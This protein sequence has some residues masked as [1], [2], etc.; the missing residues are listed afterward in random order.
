MYSLIDFGMLLSY[1]T[2]KEK[3]QNFV[4]DSLPS[5]A[6]LGHPGKK[7]SEA[8]E[9]LFSDLSLGQ[10]MD[11]RSRLGFILHICCCTNATITVN[12]ILKLMEITEPSKKQSISLTSIITFTFKY[13][14]ETKKSEL[15]EIYRNSIMKHACYNDSE[16]IQSLIRFLQ[17]GGRFYFPLPEDLMK[18]FLNY[19]EK[20]SFVA[21]KVISSI[22]ELNPT[23]YSKIFWEWYEKTQNDGNFDNIFSL[24]SLICASNDLLPPKNDFLDKIIKHCES[25]IASDISFVST[26]SALQVYKWLIKHKYCVPRFSINFKQMNLSAIAISCYAEYARYGDLS[27]LPELPE[28]QD[29]VLR[30]AYAEMIYKASFNPN[31]S[32]LKIDHPI[33]KAIKNEFFDKNSNDEEKVN[34][35]QLSI[36][37]IDVCIEL[38]HLLPPYFFVHAMRASTQNIDLMSR[39]ISLVCECPEPVLV[40]YLE[41]FYSFVERIINKYP[42]LAKHLAK[43]IRKLI[44][45][46]RKYIG[47]LLSRIHPINFFNIDELSAKFIVIE[48]LISLSR[49][50]EYFLDDL[51]CLWEV[52]PFCRLSQSFC[53]ALFK[54]FEAISNFSGKETEITNLA[55][56]TI[57]PIFGIAMPQNI[58]ILQ[59][60]FFKACCNFCSVTINDIISDPLFDL[61]KSF[62]LVGA[63]LRVICA[64]PTIDNELTKIFIMIL[65]RIATICPAEATAAANKYLDLGLKKYK[66][67]MMVFSDFVKQ[68]VIQCNDVPFI[69]QTSIF[70]AKLSKLIGIETQTLASSEFYKLTDDIRDT[71]LVILMQNE[72]STFLLTKPEQLSILLE[73]WYTGT[74]AILLNTIKSAAAKTVSPRESRHFR[75]FIAAFGISQPEYLGGDNWV[76]RTF[77]DNYT[78]TKENPK[79]TKNLTF[80]KNL[81]DNKENLT[82]V[83]NMSDVKVNLTSDKENLTNVKET[84]N[85]KDVLMQFPIEADTEIDKIATFI[86]E[87]IE[88]K[89][90]KYINEEIIKVY[91]E[92]LK[93]RFWREK[94]FYRSLIKLGIPLPEGLISFKDSDFFVNAILLRRHMIQPLLL[95]DKI[96][97]DW[98][99]IEHVRMVAKPTPPMT[100]IVKAFGSTTLNLIFW[101]RTNTKPDFK[102]NL[103]SIIMHSL[104]SYVDFA[105]SLEEAGEPDKFVESL[106]LQIEEITAMMNSCDWRN[107]TFFITLLNFT[108]S[109]I[110]FAPNEERLYKS[111][112]SVILYISK[113]STAP[114]FEASDVLNKLASHSGVKQLP[115]GFAQGKFAA[116]SSKML[117]N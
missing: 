40:A 101:A 49:D 96:M 100:E 75:E 48:T 82:I 51:D 107:P 57:L 112:L 81:S 60:K 80:T 35:L 3:L 2:N 71:R 111:V 79:F 58:T 89:K 66:N 33:W 98:L 65:P 1:H 13:I 15:I 105:L 25:I 85:I 99:L 54:Y 110:S 86:N 90:L 7:L 8:I 36:A 102:S 30:A 22:I 44:V 83:K 69:M 56:C 97:P 73:Q 59:E 74:P 38:A 108:I 17:N 43:C 28:T 93:S 78:F 10:I 68:F 94:W 18:F 41:D 47:E 9:L 46:L 21:G 64:N 34:I 39:M 31:Y 12:Y 104:L 95:S 76:K 88:D 109:L 117:V 84:Q 11:I 42:S 113:S 61:K 92:E 23:R 16:H 63:C 52:L 77:I 29:L 91:L 67:E 50:L 106:R 19:Y 4:L 27:I 32:S 20:H 5:L 72:F 116:L 26:E 6:P 87:H 45:P 14:S 24:L 114:I 115:K 70:Q 53:V 37:E 55:I 103:P 62:P